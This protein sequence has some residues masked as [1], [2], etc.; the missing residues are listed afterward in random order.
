[1]LY[2]KNIDTCL[3]NSISFILFS[4][5]TNADLRPTHPPT[6]TWQKNWGEALTKWLVY[7]LIPLCYFKLPTSSLCCY[8][9]RG[10]GGGFR[11]SPRNL[12]FLGCARFLH[13]KIK[14]A[15]LSSVYFSHHGR[16][17]RSSPITLF[18]DI[19]SKNTYF[20]L[21][22]FMNTALGQSILYLFSEISE[23]SL[24]QNLSQ[25]P[26][27]FLLNILIFSTVNALYRLLSK[28]GKSII[29]N[30]QFF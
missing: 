29:Q 19:Y 22:G 12:I 8:S 14:H 17:S 4:I 9:W 26:S 3:F 28:E 6:R 25:W 30:H 2:T 21:E 20:D 13:F 24:F 16:E 18:L 15:F 5:Q 27:I 7:S 23:T 10:K 11:K 1:M